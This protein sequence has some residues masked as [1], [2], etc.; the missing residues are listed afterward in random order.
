[1]WRWIKCIIEKELSL[2]KISDS[3]ENRMIKR[4]ACFHC[5]HISTYHHGISHFKII[6]LM[7][8]KLAFFPNTTSYTC[9]GVSDREST[10]D[11][12]WVKHPISFLT[13]SF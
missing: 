12:M 1:M 2:H 9:A 10:L 11:R 5:M 8:S 4:S 13:I 3:N 7:R 6:E